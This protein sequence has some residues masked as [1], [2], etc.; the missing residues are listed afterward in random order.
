MAQGGAILNKTRLSLVVLMT[1]LFA[2]AGRLV[3]AYEA[4]M[5]WL[6][7]LVYKGV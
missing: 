6:E 7:R 5:G 1:P 4:V 3:D 2:I